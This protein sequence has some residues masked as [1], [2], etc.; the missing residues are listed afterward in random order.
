MNEGTVSAQAAEVASE[1]DG[2]ARPAS[3]APL[4]PAEVPSRQEAPAPRVSSRPWRQLAA[5][6]QRRTASTPRTGTGTTTGV[7]TGTATAA[8]APPP[9]LAIAAT[10]PADHPEDS[11]SPRPGRVSAPIRA[12]A[13]ITGVV[14]V[15]GA[16]AIALQNRDTVPAHPPK[17]GAAVYRV[18]DHH[19]DGA[20]NGTSAAH[21]STLSG[22]ASAADPTGTAPAGSR[23]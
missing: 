14:L 7:T 17:S 13:A 6:S 12:A 18:D 1:S 20:W 23:H 19:L 3:P 9:S 11:G 15:G 16:F 8:A 22:G 21:L 2:G 4:P 10:A 5:L